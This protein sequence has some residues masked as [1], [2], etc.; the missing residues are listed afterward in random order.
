MSVLLGIPLL[1]I[2]SLI[3]FALFNKK[4]KLLI[5]SITVLWTLP[6]IAFVLGII[7]ACPIAYFVTDLWLSNFAYRTPINLWVF[8]TAAASALA[9]AILTVGY[10]SL[11]AARNNPVD[12]LRSD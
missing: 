4:K 10:Q 8:A 9:I 2:A 7:L 5:I 1:L 11:A 6:I 3:L 12:V